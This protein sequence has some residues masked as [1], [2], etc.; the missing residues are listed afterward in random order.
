M[1]KWVIIFLAVVFGGIA[2]TIGINRPWHSESCTGL[3]GRCVTYKIHS[4][5]LLNEVHYFA[6]NPYEYYALY[7]TGGWQT[8]TEYPSGKSAY[9]TGINLTP[10]GMISCEIWIDGTRVQQSKPVGGFGLAICEHLIP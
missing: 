3:I 8:T 7:V 1:K 4:T 6:Y 9:I 5:A 2:I 10:T